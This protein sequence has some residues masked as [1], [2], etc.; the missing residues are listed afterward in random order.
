MTGHVIL[1]FKKETV[2]CRPNA[3]M[4]DVLV[5]TGPYH[6]RFAD[7]LALVYFYFLDTVSL[8]K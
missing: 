5:D 3:F 8:L 1:L 6:V 2:V 4:W 7:H